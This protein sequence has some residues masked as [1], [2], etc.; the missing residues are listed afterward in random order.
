MQITNVSP[1][2]W[3]LWPV[4]TLDCYNSSP[5]RAPLL[6][7][8]GR[9]AADPRTDKHP[10]SLV[11]ENHQ[12]KTQNHTPPNASPKLR[13]ELLRGRPPHPWSWYST[14]LPIMCMVKYLPTNDCCIALRIVLR[15]RLCPHE[16]L[17]RGSLHACD[18]CLKERSKLHPEPL[19]SVETSNRTTTCR[20]TNNGNNQSTDVRSWPVRYGN[21]TSVARPLLCERYRTLRGLSWLPGPGPGSDAFALR[22]VHFLW[23]VNTFTAEVRETQKTQ[24]DGLRGWCHRQNSKIE[25]SLHIS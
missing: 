19:D 20:K 6:L 10:H 16:D 3:A 15:K 5:P 8:N 13:T 12:A 25:S 23:H 7:G 2:F 9:G 11:E 24:R 4:A 14:V 22:V 17:A 21:Q 18:M 1:R